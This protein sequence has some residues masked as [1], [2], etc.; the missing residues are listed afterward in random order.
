MGLLD[1]ITRS[2]PLFHGDF[3]NFM[4]FNGGS[5][6]LTEDNLRWLVGGLE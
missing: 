2:I 3:M 1:V 5:S 4:R 6:T